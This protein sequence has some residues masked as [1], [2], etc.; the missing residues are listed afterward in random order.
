M[1]EQY[2]EIPHSEFIEKDGEIVI[3]SIFMF[4]RGQADYF[5]FMQA[6]RKLNCTVYFA[7]ENFTVSPTDESTETRV[8]EMIYFQMAQL[9]DLVEQYLSFLLHSK[10]MKWEDVKG[11]HEPILIPDNA[12]G[13]V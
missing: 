13:G 3:P 8:R 5:P 1:N 6:C 4:S 10:D 7:N 2:K 11:Q 9:P 12:E